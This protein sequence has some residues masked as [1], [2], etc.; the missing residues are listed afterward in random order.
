MSRPPRLAILG[1]AGFVGSAC[2]QAALAA[3]YEC[4]PVSRA[5]VDYTR[6]TVL[7]EFL[8]SARPDFLI[9]CAG[10]TGR[11]NVDACEDHKTECLAG[12]AVLPGI[13][14]EA[15]EQAGIPWGHVSSGCIYNGAKADGRGFT[16]E[17]PP[18]FCFRSPPCSFYSGC[19]ALGEEVLAGA[20]RCYIW[21]LRIPFNEVDHPRNYLTKLMRYE[22]LLDAR[23][24]LSQLDEFARVCLECWQRQVPFG[25]YNVTN[26]G[27]VTTREV[28]ALIR[29]SGV[30]RKEFR[31]F[32]SEAEFMRLAARAPRSNCVLDTGKLQR[33][34]I[35]MTEIHEAIEQ[36]LR[37][38]RTA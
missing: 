8:E 4:W 18:N 35:R 25:I 20:A 34:G 6:P 29:H 33:A 31:F 24:S 3:G 37:K 2:Q 5:R 22:R 7:R 32:E 30:V 15:C 13:I 26:P 1:A 12:N 10:Y 36:A 14:R 21:R 17:D 38:W 27:S 9:N 16:E 28:V 11:P 23:N 19:K